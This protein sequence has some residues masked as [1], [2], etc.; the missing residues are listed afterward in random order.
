MSTVS[1]SLGGPG[2]LT[3]I[4][5]AVRHGWWH[6][7]HDPILYLVLVDEPGAGVRRECWWVCREC[8]GPAPRRRDFTDQE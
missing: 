1:V 5:H 7:R 2:A 3:P 8:D 6:P 4:R